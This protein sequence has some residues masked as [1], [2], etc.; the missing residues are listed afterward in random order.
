MSDVTARSFDRWLMDNPD[1]PA[2][3]GPRRFAVEFLF[4]GVKEARACLFAGLFFIAIFITPRDGLS[5]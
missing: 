2:L 1:R 3:A 4:F 5:T